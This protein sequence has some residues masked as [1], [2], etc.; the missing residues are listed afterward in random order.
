MPR[1]I[2]FIT[3]GENWNFF[4]SLPEVIVTVDALI[5]QL[6]DCLVWFISLIPGSYCVID[7]VS[8]S[9]NFIFKELFSTHFQVV[10]QHSFASIGL[11]FLEFSLNVTFSFYM[12]ITDRRYSQLSVDTVAYFWSLW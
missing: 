12:E 4:D 9:D 1:H 8:K 10:C 11:F 6:S 7:I 3:I 5:T 2:V